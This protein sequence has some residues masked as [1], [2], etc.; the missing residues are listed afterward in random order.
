MMSIDQILVAAELYIE[1]GNTQAAL[2]MLGKLAYHM[3]E[4]Y[5]APASITLTHSR[6]SV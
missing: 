5:Q 3:P 4:G 1:A 2:E 6:E